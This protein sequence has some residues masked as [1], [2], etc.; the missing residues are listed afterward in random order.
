MKSAKQISLTL[1]ETSPC[2]YVSAEDFFGKHCGKRRICVLYPIGELY[3]IS[4][5]CEI[6]V[7]KLFQFGRV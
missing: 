4:I 3:A 7:C 2:F 6:V 5:K 1:S